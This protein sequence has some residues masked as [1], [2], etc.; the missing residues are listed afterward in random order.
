[1]FADYA[2]FE[3]D[4]IEKTLERDVLLLAKSREAAMLGRKGTKG[5]S[6]ASNT[7]TAIEARENASARG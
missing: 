6:R 4:S 5:Y 2:Y 1:V 7:F 3:R